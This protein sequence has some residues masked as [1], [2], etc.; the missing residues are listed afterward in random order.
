MSSLAT[1]ADLEAWL[2]REFAEEAPAQQALDIASD[3][4]RNYCGHSISQILNDT[5]VLDGTGTHTLLLPAAPVNGIDQIEVNGEAL[6]STDYKWSKKGWVKR[7]DGL[8][9]P[10]TP[11]SVEVIFNHGYATIPNDIVGV[12]LSLSSRAVDGANNIKQETIG[13][14]S[15]TYG[16]TSAVLRADEK[17]ILDTYKVSL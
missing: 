3:I 15:V 14:Y 2:G 5:V 13:S 1:V 7:V 9:F 16:D 11:G 6:D 8:L 17:M 4:V 10:T 12:V